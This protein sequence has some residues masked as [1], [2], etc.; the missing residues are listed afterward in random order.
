MS[1]VARH[2][3][4]SWVTVTHIRDHGVERKA[5][6]RPRSV[7]TDELV[8]NMKGAMSLDPNTLV[9][10]LARKTRA[11]AMTMHWLV[12]EDLGMRSYAKQERALLSDATW[13]RRKERATLLLNRLKRVDAGATLIFSDKKWFTLE[14][15]HNRQNT[16]VVLPQGEAPDDRR[17]Q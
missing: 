6:E 12:M 5:H 7:R 16:K 9:W 1:K 15:Y 10:A 8:A 13:A 14:Q 17:V 2:T 11:S 3:G 4:A